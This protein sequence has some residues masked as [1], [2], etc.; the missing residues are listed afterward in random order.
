MGS[1][2]HL[3]FTTQPTANLAVQPVVT[4]LDSGNAT[5]ATYTGTVTLSV[6]SGDETGALYG[7]VAVAAVSGVATFAGLKLPANGTFSLT[8]AATGLTSAVSN[9]FTNTAQNTLYEIRKAAR[10]RLGFAL[11]G[12]DEDATYT[13]LW[14]F[15]I[16]QAR[17]NIVRELAQSHLVSTVSTVEV[18]LVASQR[19]YDLTSLGFLKIDT[20]DLGTSTVRTRLSPMDEAPALFTTLGDL[21]ETGYPQWYYMAGAGRIG[22]VPLPVDNTYSLWLTGSTIANHITEETD[23]TGIGELFNEAIALKAAIDIAGT[24]DMEQPE[25]Q[26]RVP[27]LIQE[28]KGT[29]GQ[30]RKLLWDMAPRRGG[31]TVSE[32]ASEFISIRR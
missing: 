13:E 30:L 4:A 16:S 1:A 20:V 17:N 9:T 7:T 19:E 27:M 14:P 11:D 21:T 28:Y 3:S 15:V 24:Y 25:H 31:V 10:F 32:A 6:T 26:K 2:T 29:M 18:P 5:D 8:A 22:L 12:G 23:T